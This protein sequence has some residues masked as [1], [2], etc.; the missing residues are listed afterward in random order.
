[1]GFKTEY[2][3]DDWSHCTCGQEIKE[4]CV[5]RRITTGEETE[6]GNV[7]VKNFMGISSGTMFDGKRHIA[8]SDTAKAGMDFIENAHSSK[9]INDWEYKFYIGTVLK[10]KFSQKQSAIR[11][12]INAK[13]ILNYV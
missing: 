10:R 9:A 8:A 2:I 13:I 12:K 3:D 6:V 4:H 5:I 7:F 1:M 11:R